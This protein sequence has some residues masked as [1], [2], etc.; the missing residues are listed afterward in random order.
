MLGVS[1]GGDVPS[2]ESI[3]PAFTADAA[4]DIRRRGGMLEVVSTG[5]SQCGL[6]LLRPL[7]VGFGE[8]PHLT[9]AR[10][11]VTWTCRSV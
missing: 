4:T 5:C 6:K 11:Q 8:T 10:I 2:E 1:V 9:T 3:F 7:L